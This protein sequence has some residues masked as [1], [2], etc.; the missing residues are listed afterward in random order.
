MTKK[1]KNAHSAEENTLTREPLQRYEQRT[2][3]QGTNEKK[4]CT[5]NH[6]TD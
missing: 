2:N 6:V 5:K 1:G 4:V 3:E